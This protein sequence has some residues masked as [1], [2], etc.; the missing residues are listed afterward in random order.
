MHPLL[1]RLFAGALMAAF[2]MVLSLAISSEYGF[3]A[4]R[5]LEHSITTAHWVLLFAA[6]PALL[7]LGGPL[8]RSAIGD[9]REG[10]LTL[11]VLFML[12]TSS[13][14]GVSVLSYV[15]ATGPIYLETATMLLALY[16]LGRYLTARAKGQTTRMLGRLLDVPDTTYERLDPHPEPV[17]PDALQEGDRVRIRAGD[18]VPVDGRILRGQSF[19]DESS[20][21]GE[22]RPVVK[23]AGDVVY[24]GTANLDG[25]LVI[26]VT[27]VADERRLARVEA[28]MREALARPPRI[29]AL[30]NRIMRWLIPGVVALSIATF[31]GWYVVAGFEKALYTS[32][33]VVLITCPCALGLAIPLVLVLALGEA[34]RKGILVRSGRALLTLAR[35]RTMLMDKTGTLS[36]LERQTVTVLTPQKRQVA[37][38]PRAASRPQWTQ[39][40][41]LQGAA[42]IETGTRHILGTAIM[43]AAHE[44]GLALLPT[45]D[46][47]TVPGTGVT[48]W[49]RA[50]GARHHV[51]VGREALLDALDADSNPALLERAQAE[52]AAGR[53]A[54]MVVVDRVLAG[55]LVLDEQVRD[56]A[57][58]A[59]HDLRQ[60]G[61][62]LQVLTGDAAPSAQRLGNALDVPVQ[63]TLTPAEKVEVLTA[64]RQGEGHAEEPVVMVGDGINDAAV[65]AE[66]DVGIALASGASISMEAADVTLYHPDLRKVAWLR[67]LAQRSARI[68]RQNLWWTFGYN[69][70]GMGLAVAGLLHPIAAVVIMTG[71]SVIVTWNAFRVRQLPDVRLQVS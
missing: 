33:S 29:M 4:V 5:E 24:A 22:A 26:Q 30:T 38:G 42:S 71:S 7:L 13:A 17:P 63:H 44:H 60:Q 27:A 68:V 15:R 69:A 49:V 35:A 53:I 23:Q 56:E 19:I 67:R 2:V 37:A 48:G 54:L 61:V 50:N 59:V 21:T 55:V 46:V 47:Q 14:V 3:S 36:A 45:E 20:L 28:M 65:L 57:P 34:S 11:N 70:V 18:V 51:G 6:V 9:L 25:A 62:T 8:L 1:L 66:A 40:Q 52:R 32:L 12:G 31:A 64:L 43:G 41:L 16:T 58:A 39:E 10:R